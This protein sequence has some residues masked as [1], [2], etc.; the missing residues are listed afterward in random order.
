MYITEYQAYEQFNEM[1][2]E[3]GPVSIA[4][5][6]FDPAAVLKEMDPTAYEESFSNYADAMGW[7]FEE[8]EDDG[9]PTEQEEWESFDPDC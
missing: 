2:N 6:E 1:L 5:I 3:A 8:E 9:Q 7:D 4:G